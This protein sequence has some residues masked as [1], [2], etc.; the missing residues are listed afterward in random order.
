MIQYHSTRAH[1]VQEHGPR[2]SLIINVRYLPQERRQSVAGGKAGKQ[3]PRHAPSWTL[4][5]RTGPRFFRSRVHTLLATHFPF[6]S[7]SSVFVISLFLLFSLSPA[8]TIS[9][10]FN[11]HVWLYSLSRQLFAVTVAL[12]LQFTRTMSERGCRYL[13]GSLI[14]RDNWGARDDLH[15]DVPEGNPERGAK[16]SDAGAKRWLNHWRGNGGCS[17]PCAPFPPAA[18]TL[19]IGPLVL[20]L[21]FPPPSGIPPPFYYFSLPYARAFSRSSSRTPAARTTL[22]Y[23]VVLAWS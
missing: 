14:S 10:S 9:G 21:I 16:R 20:S 13:A 11:Y 1:I 23:A 12:R 22:R 8:A 15:E 6:F 4:R 3:G 7:F 2:Y 17:V 19:S 5:T 18:L